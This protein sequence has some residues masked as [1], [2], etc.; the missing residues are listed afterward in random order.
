MPNISFFP[1]EILENIASHLGYDNPTS[2]IP[3][4]KVSKSFNLFFRRFLFRDIWIFVSHDNYFE[5]ECDLEQIK[6]TSLENPPVYY[7][8]TLITDLGRLLKLV[9]LLS[10]RLDLLY[11]VEHF[12]VSGL[13]FDPTDRASSLR[14]AELMEDAQ[15]KKQYSNLELVFKRSPHKFFMS[16]KHVGY[17]KSGIFETSMIDFFTSTERTS[18]IRR[19][20]NEQ[21]RIANSRDLYEAISGPTTSIF[22]NTDK[23][24]MRDTIFCQAEFNN[25]IPIKVE[26]LNAL[27]KIFRFMGTHKFKTASLAVLNFVNMT[28]SDPEVPQYR[29]GS[30]GFALDSTSNE[31]THLSFNYYFITPFSNDV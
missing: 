15:A 2:Y 25:K 6:R 3:L 1:V 22:F 10:E 13:C 31:L 28:V 4:A 29:N 7:Q 16:K 26:F 17:I 14:V 23:G 24:I 20:T 8:R 27:E 11:L 5:S 21:R 18:N 12:H 9:N 30:F 19:Y